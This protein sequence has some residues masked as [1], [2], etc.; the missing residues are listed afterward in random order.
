MDHSTKRSRLLI[1]KMGN[2]NQQNLMM[3]SCPS[4]SGSIVGPMKIERVEDTSSSLSSI[5]RTAAVTPVTARCIA[6]Q[7]MNMNNKDSVREKL[8]IEMENE[9]AGKVV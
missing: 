8:G 5:H 1:Q 4:T 9:L 3:N 2:N 6:F 7:Q